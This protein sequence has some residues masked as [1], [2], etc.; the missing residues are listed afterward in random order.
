MKDLTPALDEFLTFEGKSAK[1]KHLIG[2][3]RYC[4]KKSTFVY[5]DCAC[6]FYEENGKP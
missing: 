6:E 2:R 1:C 3:R 5:G 4:V